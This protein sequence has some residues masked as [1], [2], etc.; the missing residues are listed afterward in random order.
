M[1]LRLRT[2]GLDVLSLPTTKTRGKVPDLA[3]GDCFAAGETLTFNSG[4]F[5]NFASD[6]VG[7][8]S[9]VWEGF[10]SGVSGAFIGE[11]SSS[12]THSDSDLVLS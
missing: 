11:T 8:V 6:V 9:G 12:S 7:V 2:T 3:E 10:A 5:R 4:V 1:G